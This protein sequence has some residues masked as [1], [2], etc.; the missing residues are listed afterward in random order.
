[1]NFITHAIIYDLRNAENQKVKKSI[2]DSKM[3]A[4]R[5]NE[6]KNNRCETAFCGFKTLNRHY[7]D[8]FF[9]MKIDI[10]SYRPS[11]SVEACSYLAILSLRRLTKSLSPGLKR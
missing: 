5:R 4:D 2:I 7:P 9:Q 8:D 11:R 10:F 6:A 3:E 1:M